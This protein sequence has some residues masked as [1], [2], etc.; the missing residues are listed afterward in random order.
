[1][2]KRNQL[3][4]NCITYLV[5]LISQLRSCTNSTL[6]DFSLRFNYQIS[7]ILEYRTYILF[8]PEDAGWISSELLFLLNKLLFLKNE[9][10]RYPIFGQN[11]YT[12]LANFT[13]F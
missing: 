2:S 3:D 12:S 6:I 11:T 5:A 7:R 9:A 4:S 13:N 8:L 1:M 10:S